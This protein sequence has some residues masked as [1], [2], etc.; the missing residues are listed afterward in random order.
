MNLNARDYRKF[1]LAAQVARRRLTLLLFSNC[2][3][4]LSFKLHQT[5]QF[6]NIVR[7]GGTFRERAA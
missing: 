1:N 6:G 2:D 4:P 7:R 5:A 3:R